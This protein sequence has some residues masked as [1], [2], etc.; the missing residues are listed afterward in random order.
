MKKRKHICAMLLFLVLCF[1]AI[2]YLC[3]N[4]TEIY[5]QNLQQLRATLRETNDTVY[6]YSLKNHFAIWL[7]NDTIGN[8]PENLGPYDTY[9]IPTIQTLYHYDLRTKVKTKLL[10]TKE[11]TL[12]L[13]NKSIPFVFKEI[14]HLSLTPDS[15]AL[16]IG[17]AYLID[18]PYGG[19]RS[20][21]YMLPLINKNCLIEICYEEELEEL[22]QDN[23]VN[24]F[25][26]NGSTI[27]TSRWRGNGYIAEKRLDLPNLETGEATWEYAYKF[28]LY[29]TSG[30]EKPLFLYKTI[31]FGESKE[32][33][34]SDDVYC[35]KEN[36]NYYELPANILNDVNELRKSYVFAHMYEI[37]DV[38]KIA[39]NEILFENTFDDEKGIPAPYFKLTI[40][41]IHR[42]LGDSKSFILVGNG[43]TIITDDN[44]FSQLDYP[45]TVIIEGYVSDT[46]LATRQIYANPLVGALFG[47]LMT[48]G[49]MVSNISADMQ[50]IERFLFHDVELLYY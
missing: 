36:G 22:S 3:R 45:H 8:I 17:D 14:N 2:T 20:K 30:E 33:C 6:A 35:R 23:A 25:V 46:E 10:T 32:V 1:F 47:E 41:S 49:A 43:F 5:I 48:L 27:N 42:S 21:I 18:W 40:N 15:M 4:P 44:R 28:Y 37:E 19:R 7:H 39:H 9:V 12:N 26:E 50:L 34:V 11:D 24:Y 16:L 29:T 13:K 38:F 31:N